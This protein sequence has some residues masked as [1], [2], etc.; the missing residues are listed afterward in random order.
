LTSVRRVLLVL[1]VFGSQALV[2]CV[3]RGLEDGF[4]APPQS[5]S[6]DLA[7]VEG[8]AKNLLARGKSFLDRG[9]AIEAADL[10]EKAVQQAPGNPEV[11]GTLA[12][13]YLILRRPDEALR[14]YGNAVA[15]D[16]V[17]ARWLSGR[18]VA[19][20]QLGRHEEAQLSYQGALAVAPEG[21]DAFA[22]ATINLALSSAITG[23]R[24]RAKH[25][26]DQL[27][28]F[29]RHKVRVRHNLALVEALGGNTIGATA[30]L[31]NDLDQKTAAK[32]AKRY[33]LLR[34]SDNPFRE[35]PIR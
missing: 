35:I 8:E 24:Q 10:F 31:G 6:S 17:N 19:L 12:R 4:Q 25:L 26:L 28:R 13:A 15:L 2:A 7:A 14:T 33:A 30:L 3:S 20:D 18:G 11:V 21:S 1:V 22:S 34:V 23:N 5:R 32:L 9:S 27:N 16:P 29:S